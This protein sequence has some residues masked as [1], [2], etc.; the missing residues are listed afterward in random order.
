MSKNMSD[1]QINILF[2]LGLLDLLVIG[3]IGYIIWSTTANVPIWIP[4]ENHPTETQQAE[5]LRVFIDLSV[6]L[7]DE[8]RAT[9]IGK[10]NL[11]DDTIIMASIEQIKGG[12]HGQDKVEVDS[13]SFKAGPFGPADGL[14]SGKYLAEVL[15]PYP[16]IQPDSVRAV[17]GENGE[18]LVGDLVIHDNIDPIVKLLEEFDI[19]V[20]TA[21]PT[22][23]PTQTSV[24]R[25]SED[26]YME[27][28]ADI[29][30]EYTDMLADLGGPIYELENNPSSL[31]DEEWQ[32]EM[33]T[34]LRKWRELNATIQNTLPPSKYEDLHAH[35]LKAT[36]HYD[37]SID[38]YFEA[39][40]NLDREKIKE[41]AAE[42]SLGT[43]AMKTFL[44]EMEM[45]D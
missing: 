1:R 5:G 18:Q 23:V 42:L 45:M 17:I 13:G 28:V 33:I 38:L 35:F 14:T 12:F 7:T 29:S 16:F 21:K 32:T 30:G 25:I 4:S 34:G 10:T 26:E 22:D 36:E 39:I 8:G 6:E 20:E 9:L 37:R 24:Q 43:E 44:I 41:S 15:T 31:A 11:P 40:N 19:A 27:F 2:V 3:T